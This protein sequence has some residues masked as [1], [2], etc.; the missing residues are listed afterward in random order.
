MQIV[1]NGI[2]TEAKVLAFVTIAIGL[3]QTI[4]ITIMFIYD[5]PDV[6]LELSSRI[7]DELQHFISGVY[8]S[9]FTGGVTEHSWILAVGLITIATGFFMLKGYKLAWIANIALI[10]FRIATIGPVFSLHYPLI[11]NGVI[12]YL[13]F[14]QHTR[15][16]FLGQTA[17]PKPN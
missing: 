14:N 15:R 13:T 12:I 2:P 10:G 16:F 8:F 9:N 4:G 6:P 11:L 1:R 17:V 3:I 5:S 7:L